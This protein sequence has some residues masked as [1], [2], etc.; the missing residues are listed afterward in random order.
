MRKLLLDRS[1]LLLLSVIFG[2]L[3]SNCTGNADNK[4]RLFHK[5]SAENTDI[6]FENSLSFDPDF[7]IQLY[8][9]FYNGGGVAIGDVTGNGL[10]DIYLTGNMVENQLYVN[11]GNFK[12]EDVT[13]STGVAGRGRWSTG[14][15]MVDINGDGFV[16]IYVTNSGELDNRRNELFISNG[17]GTFIESAEEY[18]LDD[19]GYSI[20]STF[21]D[22]NNDDLLDLYLINNSNAL[23]GSFEL[24]KNLRNERDKLGGDKLYKNIGG[25]FKDVTE[26]AGLYGSVIGFAL[27]ATASD[28]NRDGFTDLF[29]ANDF[30]EKDYLYINQGDETFKEVISDEVIRSMSFSSMGSDIAD[31]NNNGWPDIYV[32]DMLPQKDERIKKTS[33][34]EDL[35]TYKRKAELGYG[36]QI[37]RNVFHLNQGGDHFLEIGRKTNTHATGWSWAVLLADFDHNGFNDIFVSNGLVGDLT[38]RDYFEEISNP[39]LISQ[40]AGDKKVNFKELIEKIPPNPISNFVFSNN[41]DL[42]FTNSA[43]KWGL[44]TPGFSSSAAWGDLNND[45]SLDLVVNNVNE[46]AW[47]YQNRSSKVYSDRSWL[48]VELEGESPNT[49]AIGAQLQVWAGDQYWFREHFLQRGYQS[50]VEPGFH[51]GLGETQKIDSLVVRW[52]DGKTTRMREVGIPAKLT[53]SQ[54]YAENIPPPPAPQPTLSGDLAKP[55][56]TIQLT[57]S[58]LTGITEWSHESYDYSDFNRESLLMRMRSTEGPA[59]CVG[60]INGDNLDDIYMGGARGQ[61]GVLWLQNPSGEFLPHQQDLFDE[62]NDSEDTDCE[63]FDATGNS[64]DDLYVV[65]GGNSFSTG[66]SSLKDRLYLNDGKGKLIKSSKALPTSRTYESGAVVR[67]NDFTGDGNIDLFVGKRLGLFAVGL[68]VNG[69]LLTGDGQGNFQD[70]TEKWAPE[71]LEIGLITDGIWADL[72]GNGNKELVVIGEWMPIRIFTYRGDHFEEITDDLELTD[73]TGWWNGI[74]AGDLDGNG[75]VD[76]IIGNHGLNSMFQAERDKPVKMWVGDFARNGRFEH[77]LTRPVGD[78][79]YP[80]ALRHDLLENIPNLRQKYQTYSSY[81]GQAVQEIFTSEQLDKSLELKAEQLSSVVIW[82]TEDG[83]SI[84]ELP[85]RA[86][87]SPMFG[88]YLEDLDDNGLPEIIMGGNLFDVKP[89]AGPYDASRGVVISYTDGKLKSHPP[90][91]NGLEVPGEIR[92]I[93]TFT[94]ANG[95]KYLIFSRFNQNPAV[96]KVN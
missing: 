62:N 48:K 3:M 34:F 83:F 8:R 93:K 39:R 68:P 74:A 46:P 42:K 1:H 55:P 64:V 65:S 43:K 6:H 82:N 10:P 27:S 80:V 13:E 91:F 73:T 53:L 50:S 87:L 84:D 17:D 94:T 88:V 60:D 20:H 89:Q 15:S 12:F 7:N 29:V 40:I 37:Q 52:P 81:A 49:L 90:Q 35:D 21:F 38:N 67:S 79:N 18:G 32:S 28:L 5:L 36:H 24:D 63:F 51:L 71:L 22:Y 30:F 59:L 31:I 86:Q 25:T 92:K 4:D 45:G 26:E 76:L 16:D 11:K 19:P 95:D 41:G 70:V 56:G 14:A 44:D 33:T 47:I 66:S 54:K 96:L 2:L 78:K 72:T 57:E 69:Y 9:N 77:I 85:F 58:H 61:S 23:I 75:R